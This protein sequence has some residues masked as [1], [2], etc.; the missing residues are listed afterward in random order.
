MDVLDNANMIAQRDTMDALGLAAETASQI[1]HDFGFV[2]PEHGEILNVV[3]AGMGGSALQAEYVRSWPQLYVPYVICKDYNIP[4]FVG[5]KTLVIVS[6]Y[7]GNTEETLSALEQAR[8]KGAMI[9]VNTGGGKL[10]ARAEEYGLPLIITP[11]A[12]QPRMVVFYTYRMALEILV[13][14]GLADNSVLEALPK[15][16]QHLQTCVQQWVK[17]VPTD[18]NPAKQ[19]AL[20][21]MGK[22]PI[23]YAGP[24]MAPAAFKWKI[25]FN[26]SAKNTSWYGVYSEFNHNEFMGWTSHPID[27][28]F[29][30]IN[31]I[32]SF[33]HDRIQQRFAVTDRLLSGMRPKAHTVMAQGES[34]LE[35]MLYLT[36]FGDFV[37]IYLGLLNGVDPSPV[38]LIEEFKKELG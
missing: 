11:K 15:V 32:S 37:T 3:F 25:G 36:L 2:A 23:I 7:S 30:V 31:L 17:S 10:Q 35:H 24:L 4:A 5:E 28:P 13:A 21:L 19:L 9:V 14:Y 16:S 26:E 34:V 8:S 38:A 27:K 33:E 12:D 18:Q 29:A 22:T 6:S 20:Q 1:T